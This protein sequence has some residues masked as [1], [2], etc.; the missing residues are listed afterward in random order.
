MLIFKRHWEYWHIP[1][2]A[3]VMKS[4]WQCVQ[5]ISQSIAVQLVKIISSGNCLRNSS[6]GNHKT[7][8]FESWTMFVS[9]WWTAFTHYWSASPSSEHPSPGYPVRTSRNIQPFSEDALMLTWICKHACWPGFL[10]TQ[11]TFCGLRIWCIFLRSPWLSSLDD[12]TL[13]LL[14]K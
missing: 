2:T 12:L 1:L 5:F 9:G 6:L 14:K 7:V 8:H 13:V 3:C 4:N 11:S 10:Q